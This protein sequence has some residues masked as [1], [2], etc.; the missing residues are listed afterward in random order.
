MDAER[1]GNLAGALA[2]YG[3][4]IGVDPQRLEAWSGVRRVARA[5]GDTLGEARALARLGALVRDPHRA[6]GLLVDA[7]EAYERAGRDDDAIAAYARAVELDPASTPAYEQAHRLLLIDLQAP[8][9][10]EILDGL[11]S[12][13]LAAA[14]L[15]GAS[16]RRCCSSAA[17]IG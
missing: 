13:R 7:G 9:R 2:A 6:A 1:A 10:A 17:G 15:S 3:S 12:Y 11:L 14:R 8:G 4:V 5:A 16:A